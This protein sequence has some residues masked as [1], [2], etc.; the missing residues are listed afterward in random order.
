MILILYG[1]PILIKRMSNCA[2]GSIENLTKTLQY[3]VD[4][5]YNVS[6]R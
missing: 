5:I 1:Y 6:V 3:F 2:A 4:K